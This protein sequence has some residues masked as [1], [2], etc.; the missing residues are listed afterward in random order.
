MDAWVNFFKK[1]I[2]EGK[3]LFITREYHDFHFAML[4]DKQESIMYHKS[5]T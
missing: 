1:L 2:G 3:R 5:T 4:S